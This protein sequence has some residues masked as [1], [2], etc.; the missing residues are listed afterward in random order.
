MSPTRR[1]TEPEGPRQSV[2]AWSRLS[3]LPARLLEVRESGELS[4]LGSYVRATIP[5]IRLFREMG[6]I[7]VELVKLGGQQRIL[8]V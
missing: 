5:S 1:E 8:R 6:S 3:G 4:K 7:L 2:K